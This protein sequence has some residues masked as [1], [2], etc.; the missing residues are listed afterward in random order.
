MR[1]SPGIDKA[2]LL[3]RK[4][5]VNR[6]RGA[7]NCAGAQRTPVGQRNH[8]LKPLAIS[9]QHFHPRKQMMREIDRLRPLQM[10]VAGDHHFR[11]GLRDGEQRTLR[12]K[13]QLD[14][15]LCSGL[16]PQPHIGRDLIIPTPRCV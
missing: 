16:E 15:I 3:R 1:T 7:R 9:I 6:Q 11:I 10:R 13:K 5:P 8:P 4:L 12:F 2:Q 14:Q